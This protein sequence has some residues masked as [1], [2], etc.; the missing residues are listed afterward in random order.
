MAVWMTP[1]HLSPSAKDRPYFGA[2]QGSQNFRKLPAVISEVAP[3]LLQ[4]NNQ[5]WTPPDV[6]QLRMPNTVQSTARA[7]MRTR[8]R[9]KPPWME[10]GAWGRNPSA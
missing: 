9:R 5:S 10:V 8:A 1:M 4:E 2:N 3:F 7:L 6:D